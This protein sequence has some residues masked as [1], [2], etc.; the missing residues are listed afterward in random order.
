MIS[1]LF[2]N[3]HFFYILL[4]S[5]YSS[6][7]LNSPLFLQTFS[8]PTISFLLINFLSLHF[9]FFLQTSFPILFF[10]LHISSLP[11]LPLFLPPTLMFFTLSLSLSP[12]LSLSLF[13]SLK[14]FKRTEFHKSY[15]NHI[16][17]L[18]LKCDLLK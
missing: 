8:F 15:Q 17:I 11:L 16:P 1:F 14:L 4:S 2:T 13:L 18:N 6:L 3:F 10:L 5:F 7:S 12:S 9:P